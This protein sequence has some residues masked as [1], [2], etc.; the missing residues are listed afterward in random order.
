MFGRNPLWS[1]AVLDFGFLEDFLF[2]IQFHCLSLEKE[3]AAHSSI[4]SWRI[5]WTEEPGRLPSLGLQRVGHD[6]ATLLTYYSSIQITYSF[7]FSL[8]RLFLGIYSFFLCCPIC[9]QFAVL[10][11]SYDFFCIYVILVVIS[12]LLFLILGIYISL[13]S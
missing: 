8:G 4:L 11:F 6:R 1:H 9:W 2:L 12:P 3:M 10:V 13:F 7:W 5:P